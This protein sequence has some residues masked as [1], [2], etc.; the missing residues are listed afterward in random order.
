MGVEQKQY[1]EVS[2]LMPSD[3]GVDDALAIL[4]A[5]EA[6]A[7]PAIIATY[8]NGSTEQTSRN[9]NSL[10]HA[11]QQFAK[12]PSRT[13]L[14]FSGSDR[15]LDAH[16]PFNTDV[17]FIHG[18]KAMEGE[19]HGF[20]A[21][22]SKPDALYRA[23]E[24]K[25]PNDIDV[26]SLGA[27]TEVSLM[28]NRGQRFIKHVNSLTLMGGTIG[29]QGNTGMYKEANF[30]H[31]PEALTQILRVA[32]QKNIPTTIVP[33]NVTEEP[34]LELTPERVISLAENLQKR[35]SKKIAAYL[36]KLLGPD[37]TYLQF[38]RSRSQIYHQVHGIPELTKY[39]GCP[40]HDLTALYARKHPNLFIYRNYPIMVSGNGEI[41]I[42]RD[43]YGVIGEFEVAVALAE[44]AGEE[45]WNLTENYLAA[46]YN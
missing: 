12:D 23:I 46:H 18:A 31:D 13:P 39:Q 10:V 37:S 7:N 32:E 28:L 20:P 26:I 6:L 21:I 17:Q 44:G 36:L 38:Y 8:G 2:E 41:G 43:Y 19:G 11:H 5:W 9:L 45:Y 35:G 40:I 27:V 22:K 14:V 3:P 24:K 29:H 4:V 33:L 34:E 16:G 25:S 1:S 42:G 30:M 15:A